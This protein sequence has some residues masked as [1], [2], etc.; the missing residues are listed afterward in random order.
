MTR[1]VSPRKAI[2]IG[3]SIARQDCNEWLIEN[4][5]PPLPGVQ[6]FRYKIGTGDLYGLTLRVSSFG[7]EEKWFWFS[8]PEQEWKPIDHN[9]W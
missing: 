9:P 5:I 1:I 4:G 3:D 8:D 6:F 2:L 7:E